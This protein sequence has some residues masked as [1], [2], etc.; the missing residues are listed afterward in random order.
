MSHLKTI[1]VPLLLVINHSNLVSQKSRTEEVPAI[2]MKN[3][4]SLK[5]YDA[6]ELYFV[7]SEV[8]ATTLIDPVV[9]ITIQNNIQKVISKYLSLPSDLDPY[10]WSF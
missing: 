4:Y 3:I 5:V 1:K 8:V 6:H 10:I 2:G 9:L 7:Y